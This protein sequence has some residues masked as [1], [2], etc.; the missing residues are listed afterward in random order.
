MAGSVA[1]AKELLLELPNTFMPG[2]FVNP[3]NWRAHYYTTAEEIWQDTQGDVDILVAGMGTGGTI[4][5]CAKRLKELNPHLY[6]V[7]VEPASS[8]LLT[9]GE[10]GPHGI[11]GIGANFVPEVYDPTVVDEVLDV[12]DEAAKQRMVEFAQWEGMLVGISAGA[13][14]QGAVELAWRPENMGKRIVV[15]LPDSGERYLSMGIFA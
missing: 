9:K 6:A 4:T 2:Q 14:L 11:Q 3:N 13:A 1:K 15:I 5:G 10:A 12:T 8:P 7:A